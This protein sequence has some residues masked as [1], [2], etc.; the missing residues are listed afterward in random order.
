MADKLVERGNQIT[1]WT[2]AFDHFKKEWIY[3]EDTELTIK[4]DYNIKVLKGIGYRKN[5][6]ISRFIDHRIVAWKF[7]RLAPKMPKPDVIVVSMPPHDLAYKVALFA[8]S[9]SIPILVDIR[10]P[11][12]DIF[13]NHIPEKFRWLLK[14]VLH[15]DFKMLR[16]TMQIADGLV[17]VTNTFLEW[18]LRN[19]GR[20]KSPNDKSYPLGYKKSKMLNDSNI[21]DNFK[22]LEQKLKDKF[23][24][25]FVGTISASY[26]NPFILLKAA[27]KLKAIK[28]MH[29]LIAGDGELLW[30]LE[31]EAANCDNITTTG[32]LNQDEIE[33]WLKS[34]R[35]GICPVNTEMDLPTNKAFAYLSAGIPI[36]SAFQGEL[37]EIIEE[38]QIGFYYPPDDVFAL[39][40]CIKKLYDDPILYKKMSENA[41]RVFNEMF[42]AEKI[43][44]EYADHI[45]KV[46]NVCRNIR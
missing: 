46:V 43:Y 15:K 1:W 19:A 2:S 35:I 10:D 45:E 29:F 26:H 39:V 25:F 33:F 36:I 13:L 41:G 23:L 16:K 11:W 8:Q 3:Q 7:K 12:P 28:N 31:K 4:K 5:L 24:I 6:S 22:S 30:Q 17:S 37:K 18:G 14:I 40:E 21:K 34:S 20:L 42:D 27:E 44:E 38:Y 32:W 9:G